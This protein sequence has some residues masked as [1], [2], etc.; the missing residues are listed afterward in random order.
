MI[1]ESWSRKKIFSQKLI[2]EIC[3]YSF[4]VMSL[5]FPDQNRIL[6]MFYKLHLRCDSN[7]LMLS[8]FFLLPVIRLLPLVRSCKFC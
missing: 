2:L 1:K 5:S 7:I 4:E 8:S 6:L 3:A